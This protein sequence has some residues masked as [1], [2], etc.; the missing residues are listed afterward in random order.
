MFGIRRNSSVMCHSGSD[1]FQFCGT[2]RVRRPVIVS[3]AIDVDNLLQ[4]C[5]VA[6]GLYD[7]VVFEF[8]KEQEEEIIIR[9][10]R[11]H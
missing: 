6:F 3:S 5:M 11:G 9:K 1:K 7:L 2:D 4:Q 10:L 8:T